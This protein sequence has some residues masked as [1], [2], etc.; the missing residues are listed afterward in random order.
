M[1]FK[2]RLMNVLAEWSGINTAVLVNP[3]RTK[4]TANPIS[5]LTHRCAS[6]CVFLNVVSRVKFGSLI[7][8]SAFLITPINNKLRTALKRKLNT[9][10][11]LKSVLAPQSINLIGKTNPWSQELAMD[12]GFFN[13]TALP[14]SLIQ[15]DASAVNQIH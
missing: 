10:L 14:T 13:A 15:A 2:P 3:A 4:A 8:A 9:K 12:R 5:S 7:T 1:E 6:A 11:F